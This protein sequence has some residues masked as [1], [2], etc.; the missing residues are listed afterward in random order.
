MLPKKDIGRKEFGE[1]PPYF[2]LRCL[3]VSTV[4]KIP[5]IKSCGGLFYETKCEILAGWGW[6]AI[7]LFFYSNVSI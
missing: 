3:T 4:T 7:N 1:E 5:L 2:R 6:L